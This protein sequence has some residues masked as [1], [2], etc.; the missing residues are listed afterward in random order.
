[1][2]DPIF[3]LYPKYFLLTHK[4]QLDNSPITAPIPLLGAFFMKD[5]PTRF[6]QIFPFGVAKLSPNLQQCNALEWNELANH[7]NLLITH[8]WLRPCKLWKY[9]NKSNLSSGARQS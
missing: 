7:H 4:I 9:L 8:N 5:A 3:C 6:S 1:M 2:D